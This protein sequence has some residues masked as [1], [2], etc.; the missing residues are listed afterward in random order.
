MRLSQNPYGLPL[1]RR[2]EHTPSYVE[3]NGVSMGSSLCVLVL[4][5]VTLAG[6]APLVRPPMFPSD[7]ASLGAPSNGPEFPAPP[8]SISDKTISLQEG[9]ST[10]E[11]CILEYPEDKDLERQRGSGCGADW[12]E[13]RS[14]VPYPHEAYQIYRRSE[15][16]LVTSVGR[17]ICRTKAH[18]YAQEL[19]WRNAAEAYGNTNQLSKR[20]RDAL[21]IAGVATSLN[22][23]GKTSVYYGL[24]AV[25]ADRFPELVGSERQQAIYLLSADAASCLSAAIEHMRPSPQTI[26]RHV[27]LLASAKR[28]KH[29]FLVSTRALID[30]IRGDKHHCISIKGEPITATNSGDHL[31]NITRQHRRGSVS[32]GVAPEAIFSD[33]NEWVRDADRAVG[34]YASLIAQM[35]EHNKWFARQIDKATYALNLELVRGDAGNLSGVQLAQSLSMM[36]H[37][38]AQSGRSAPKEFKLRSGDYLDYMLARQRLMGALEDLA[39]ANTQLKDQMDAAKKE[40]EACTGGGNPELR[41]TPSD[42]AIYFSSNS[43]PQVFRVDDSGGTPTYSLTGRDTSVFDVSTKSDGSGLTATVTLKKAAATGKG[44]FSAVLLFESKDGKRRA[45]PIVLQYSNP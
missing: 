44:P 40:A 45:H 39:A 42:H 6:C 2:R 1:F 21:A 3:C 10:L 20:L 5:L 12:L 23:I 36:V 35:I 28:S 18:I 13:Q 38:T 41:V 26:A 32:C 27:N 15:Y 11:Q 25:V 34:N 9:R 31:R 7:S 24:A 22:G 8:S 17:D 30:S 16:K 43:G 33:S 19:N 29:E 14:C 4:F 37:G